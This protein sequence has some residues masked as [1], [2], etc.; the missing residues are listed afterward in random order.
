MHIYLIK[1]YI[2][3]TISLISFVDFIKYKINAFIFQEKKK[4]E[5]TQIIVFVCMWMSFYKTELGFPSEPPI[6]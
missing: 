3:L 6:S 1:S 2:D 5:G 4:S